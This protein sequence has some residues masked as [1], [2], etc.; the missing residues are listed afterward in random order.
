MYARNVSKKETPP[1]LD[2]KAAYRITG[3]RGELD[4]FPFPPGKSSVMKRREEVL[5]K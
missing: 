3:E 5:T 2:Q 1:T 4:S